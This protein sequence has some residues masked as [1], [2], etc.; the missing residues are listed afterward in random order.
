[1]PELTLGLFIGVL[2]AVALVLLADGQD[3]VVKASF[4]AGERRHELERGSVTRR[5]MRAQEDFKLAPIQ[6]SIVD[7]LKHGDAKTRREII[8]ELAY[9]LKEPDTVLDRALD[10]MITIGVIEVVEDKYFRLSDH[11]SR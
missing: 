10:R 11:S 1:M 9:V 7:L 3:P 8:N 6:L 5:I 2:I 4:E